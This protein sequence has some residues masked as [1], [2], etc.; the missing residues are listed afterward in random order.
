MKI[1]IANL[2][3]GVH[4]FHFSAEPVH[5]GLGSNF[6]NVVTI[7][8]TLEKTNRELLLHAEASTVGTFICDRCIDEF[9]QELRATY[10]IVYLYDERE[11]Y[12]Y[13]D[14]EVQ[15]IAVGTTVIDITDDVRQYLL[16][17]VPVKL[18]CKEGCKGLCPHCGTNH[19]YH[20]C[21]CETDTKDSRWAALRRLQQ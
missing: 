20:A 4:A 17:A 5:F 18:L 2:S 19:N 12:R 11:T 10:E 6:D 13:P 16:L 8:V 3:E 1:S 14:D 9:R 15:V 7:D 21:S